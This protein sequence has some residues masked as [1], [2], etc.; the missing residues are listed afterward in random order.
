MKL[1]TLFDDRLTDFIV[2]LTVIINVILAIVKLALIKLLLDKLFQ[3][4]E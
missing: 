2:A 3:S 1:L 4:K